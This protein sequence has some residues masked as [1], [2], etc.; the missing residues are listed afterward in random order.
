MQGRTLIAGG[1]LRKKRGITGGSVTP[2]KVMV[3]NWLRFVNES[4]I[5]EYIY[6]Y[7]LSR[8]EI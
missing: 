8:E 3:K 2:V 7:I 6:K 4:S 5:K 1:L